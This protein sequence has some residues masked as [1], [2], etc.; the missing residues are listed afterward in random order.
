MSSFSVQDSSSASL[1][2][3]PV[4]WAK[5]MLICLVMHQN[6]MP[7]AIEFNLGVFLP[8]LSIYKQLLDDALISLGSFMQTKHLCVLIHI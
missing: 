1:F 8:K 6:Q 5:L 7:L 2:T 3:F 4:T